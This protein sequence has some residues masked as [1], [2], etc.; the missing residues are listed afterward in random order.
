MCRF[1]PGGPVKVDPGWVGLAPGSPTNPGGRLWVSG[2][3]GA[4]E[5]LFILKTKVE[6][7][8]AEGYFSIVQGISSK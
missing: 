2:S 8:S 4:T 7:I 3:R 1:E 5:G 6:V